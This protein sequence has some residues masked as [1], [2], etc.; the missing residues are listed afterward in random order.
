MKEFESVNVNYSISKRNFTTLP[1]FI[2]GNILLRVGESRLQAMKEKGTY[3]RLDILENEVK[4]TYHCE[5][6]GVFDELRKYR[7]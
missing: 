7:G 2:K 3:Y 1:S 4:S 6:A 5:L